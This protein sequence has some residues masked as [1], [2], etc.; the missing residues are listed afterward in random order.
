MRIRKSRLLAISMIC[1]IAVGNSSNGHSAA[2][3][4]VKANEVK[5]TIQPTMW[6]IFFEDINFDADGGL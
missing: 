6:G 1:L 5:A 4:T 2:V 3:I